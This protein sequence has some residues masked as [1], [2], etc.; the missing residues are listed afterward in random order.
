MSKFTKF[1]MF[2]VLVVMILTLLI[3]AAPAKAAENTFGIYVKHDING[4]SLGLDKALP[5][6]VYVN[7]GKAFTFEFGDSFSADLPAGIYTIDVKLAGTD[8]TVMSLGPVEI[9]A[10]VDVTI[11]A[12]LSA[13]KT[14]TLHV[15][16]K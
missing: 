7:G 16:V 14:P 1:S 2:G 11:K 12:Q 5:V 9:P 15:N 13:N 6:D 8:T 10:D 4:R 3:S